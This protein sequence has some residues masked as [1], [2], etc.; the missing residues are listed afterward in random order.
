MRTRRGRR[1]GEQ[2]ARDAAVALVE[3]AAGAGLVEALGLCL[4]HYQQT[5]RLLP[6]DLAEKMF[7]KVGRIK[8][9]MPDEKK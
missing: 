9:E 4:R 6:S 8:I 7:S 3:A 1:I 5:E 2:Q